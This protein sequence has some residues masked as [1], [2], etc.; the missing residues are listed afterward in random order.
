MYAP[1]PSWRWAPPSDNILPTFS[2]GLALTLV[3]RVI[4]MVVA[5]ITARPMTTLFHGY[6]PDY[7][8]A[9]S[10]RLCDAVKGPDSTYF[11]PD[12]A[13]F[14]WSSIALLRS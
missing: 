14:F 3:G 9:G 5:I 2:R 7:V 11:A 12:D 10:R 13:F 4:G 1:T 8:P 6:R